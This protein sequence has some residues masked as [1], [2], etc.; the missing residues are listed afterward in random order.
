VYTCDNC[1]AAVPA[2]RGGTGPG[3][4]Y[5]CCPACVFCP[6]GCRCKWGEFGV[7][8]TEDFSPEFEAQWDDDGEC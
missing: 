4:N 1:G 2:G 7:K 8:E 6:L 3:G 5:I